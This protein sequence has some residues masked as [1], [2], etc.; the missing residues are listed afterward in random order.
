MNEPF[1]PD[2]LRAALAALAGSRP[3]RYVCAVSGGADSLS[4][5]HA[6]ILC[7]VDLRLVHVNHHLHPDSDRWARSVLAF[8]EDHNVPAS[9]LDVRPDASCNVEAHAREARYAALA[10]DL[11]SEEVL[12]T[13]HHQD[14]QAL[15]LLLQLLR[16]AGVAGLASMP[17]RGTCGPA[18]HWRPLLGVSGQALLDYAQQHKLPV[19]AD[20]SNNE[21]RFGRNLLRKDV[22]PLL[23]ARWPS[24]ARTLSRT[25]THCAEADALLGEL[26]RED[27]LHQHS[28]SVEVTHCDER[29]A[30]NLL[31]FFLRER[32]IQ[33]PATTRLREFLRQV[34][35]ASEDAAPKLALG[36]VA[37]CSFERR[38]FI[39]GLD[40]PVPPEALTL[41]PNEPLAVPH[42][43]LRWRVPADPAPLTVRFRSGGERF[44]QSP[45]RRLKHFFQQRRVLPWRRYQVPLVWHDERIVA[46]ADWWQDAGLPGRI[47][48]SPDTS[49]TL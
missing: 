27:G 12:L 49:F 17:V 25:A 33:L 42:G 16:G 39:V 5:A 3:P 20:P 40:E 46:I 47:E 2:F 23:A 15:T 43:A 29:R 32:Q 36:D 44:G 48:W 26:A 19:V 37:L 7:E 10:A 1:S 24:F 41:Q 22:A 45:S 9:S 38:V 28:Q 14:D 11:R 4:L 6:L 31:R 34:R 8:A 18:E 21:D 13:A 30:M 35:T